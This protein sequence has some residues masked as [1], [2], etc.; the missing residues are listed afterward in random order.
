MFIGSILAD[1][2]TQGM[3][4]R[5]AGGDSGFFSQLGPMLWPLLIMSATGLTVITER[6][7]FFRQIQINSVEFLSG[8]RNVLKSGNPVEAI[9]I[10][11][12]TPGPVARLMKAAILNR[13]AG[14]ERVQEA[15]EEVGLVEVPKLEARLSVLA[16][17]AQIAPLCGLLGTLLGLGGVYRSLQATQGHSAPA[18]LFLGVGESLH[19]AGMGMA[20]AIISYAAYNYL[21]S[22]V[23]AIVLD[24]ERASGEALRM[25]A[26]DAA[27]RRD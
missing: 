6:L 3:V 16:T 1:V 20:I 22:R 25:T 19:A 17:L 23:N 21:V 9:A 11:D 15:V 18:D 7:L 4:V 10:C 24:M 27:V 5:A 14:R 13:D 26:N 12:A 8:V 2:A